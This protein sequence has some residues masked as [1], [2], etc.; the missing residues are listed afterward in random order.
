MNSASLTI[1]SRYWLHAREQ[2]DN[3]R[4]LVEAGNPTT[5]IKDWTQWVINSANDSK[6]GIDAR[7]PSFIVRDC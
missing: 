7:C 1:D 5:N 2:L 3:N 4:A 6:I